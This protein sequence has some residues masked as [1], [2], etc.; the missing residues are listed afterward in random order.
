MYNKKVSLSRSE[1]YNELEN[2]FFESKIS[3]V[4]LIEETTP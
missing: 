1:R 3:L 2:Q 4:I